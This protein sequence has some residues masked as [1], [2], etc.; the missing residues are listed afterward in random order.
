MAHQFADAQLPLRAAGRAAVAMP[1]L[2]VIS[3]QKLFTAGNIPP[4]VPSPMKAHIMTGLRPGL[5]GEMSGEYLFRSREIWTHR[6]R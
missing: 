6:L 5:Y 1:S 2:R 3:F 4:A